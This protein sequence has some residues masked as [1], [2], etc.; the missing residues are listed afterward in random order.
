MASVPPD[1]YHSYEDYSATSANYDLSRVPLGLSLLRQVLSEFTLK[2]TGATLLDAGCGT[3]SY[4]V[5]LSGSIGRLVGL[6]FNPGMLARAREKTAGLGNVT[7]HGGSVL[8][9][10]FPDATF[11]AV[12]FNQVIHHL[13]TPSSGEEGA[14]PRLTTALAESRRVLKEG[15]LLVIN[16]CR[17][18]QVRDGFW[19]TILVPEATERLAARY[20]PTGK[21]RAL[22]DRAGFSVIREAVPLDEMFGGNRYL[23]P[24]GPFDKAWRDSDSFWALAG[25]E[26][27]QAGLARLREIIRTGGFPRFAEEREARRKR[28]GQAIFLVGRE[29]EP[30]S[31]SDQRRVSGNPSA[32]AGTNR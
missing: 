32:D 25:P 4:L 6:E 9:M 19:Y 8:E 27:L 22:L 13:D 29:R 12:M 7:L 28:V 15:G 31:G 21:L 24:E 16:T 26:E 14:W 18:E 20:V 2:G 23:D 3:G 11:D 10:P 1:L 5:A 17:R 30:S